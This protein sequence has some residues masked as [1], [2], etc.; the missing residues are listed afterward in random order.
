MAQARCRNGHIYDPD[1]FGENCPY[2]DRSATAIDFDRSMERT[3]GIQGGGMDAFSKS[4]PV[5]TIAPEEIKKTAPPKEFT[6][7]QEEIGKTRPAWTPASGTDPVVGWLVCVQG[8]ELGKDYRLYGR[9]NM[10]GRSGEMD[11][12]IRGDDTITSNTHAKI[13]YDVLNNQ[14]YLLPGNNKNT[15]YLNMA[16]VYAA[17]KLEAYDRLRFGKT[18]LIFIPLCSEKFRWPTDGKEI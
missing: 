5:D 7:K 18:E 14:F 11:V 12:Q 4:H 8:H 1:I 13:D 16:P 17:Q 6:V 3:V 10:I 9:T 15:I 2:C